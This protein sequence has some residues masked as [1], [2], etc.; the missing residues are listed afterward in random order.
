M[1]EPHRVGAHPVAQLR[2]E[3]GRRRDL[4]DL[5]VAALHRAVALEEVDHVALAV[6]EDLHLDVA[7]LDDGL[8]DEDGRVAE[9]ALALA[10]AGL[11]RLAQQLRVVDPAHAA[12]AAAG[13]GLD[14]E[15]VRQ[16]GGRLDQGVDVGGRLDARQRGHAGGLGRRDRARL[17]AGQLEHVGGRADEGDAGVGAR[18][19]ERRVLRE[20]AVARV[21]RVGAAP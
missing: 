18:L 10:H 14:E 15:R 9:G 21:D 3:V 11:D 5:L 17:V 6:G 7:R 13:D 16:R 19:G 2:V 20:E 1:R 12:T 8:L 4:D